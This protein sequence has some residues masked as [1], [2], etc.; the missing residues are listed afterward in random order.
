MNQITIAADTWRKLSEEDART[1][2]A[3]GAWLRMMQ[4]KMFW[5]LIASTV[6]M[7]GQGFQA[8][9][10]DRALHRT[11]ADLQALHR[12]VE[13]LEAWQLEACAAGDDDDEPSAAG[14]DLICPLP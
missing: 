1:S 2:G 3:L 14:D 6:G 5:L 10:T 11:T 13:Q 9:T 8:Y 7:F 4:R 12:R